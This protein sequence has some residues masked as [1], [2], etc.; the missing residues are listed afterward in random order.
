MEIRDKHV[1]GGK[2]HVICS[3]TVMPKELL[4][5]R[6]EA[7]ILYAT[8]LSFDHGV[9]TM[10]KLAKALNVRVAEFFRPV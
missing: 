3:G 1:C 2:L 7:H 8:A 10:T 9:S 6:Y 4:R 5:F